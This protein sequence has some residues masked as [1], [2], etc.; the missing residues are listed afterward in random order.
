MTVFD[1]LGSRMRERELGHG[2]EIERLLT[3]IKM[4]RRALKTQMDINDELH[5]EIIRQ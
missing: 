3:E 4:L 1:E 5:A 2:R